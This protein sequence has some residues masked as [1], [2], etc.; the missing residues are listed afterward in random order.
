MAI[1]PRFQKLL[2]VVVSVVLLSLCLRQY[3]QPFTA[4]DRV[5]STESA[6][7]SEVKTA[8]APIAEREIVSGEISAP[9]TA[10]KN[11]PQPALVTGPA[12]T[13]TVRLSKE[14]KCAHLWLPE[15]LVGRCFGLKDHTVYPEFK[16]FGAV[17][18]KEE[19]QALCCEL[20]SCVTW[21]YWADLKVCKLGGPTRL[22]NEGGESANWCEPK[23]PVQWTGRLK[24]RTASYVGNNEK[25]EWAKSLPSQCFGLG[26]ERMINGERMTALQC[27]QSCCADHNCWIF[28]H[29]PSKGCFHDSGGDGK[30][31]CETYIGSFFGSRKCR[32]Q[33]GGRCAEKKR[34][35]RANFSSIA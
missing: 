18:K 5:A 8:A 33:D 15:Q 19:C 9:S 26:P 34:S 27:E 3:Y 35:F 7:G 16:G 1:G 24:N 11:G 25:C 6:P 12:D 31:F 29:H 13:A 17:N 4:D 23:P 28:Q 20:D 32:P 10:V 2:C 21:Q 22:G 14:D 30:N